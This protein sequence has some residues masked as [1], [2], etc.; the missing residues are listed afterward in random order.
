MAPS[1]RT[2]SRP[3]AHPSREL[4]EVDQGVAC[5]RKHDVPVNNFVVVYGDI[6]ETYGSA[7]STGQVGVDGTAGSQA[8]E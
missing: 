7:Q 5:Q 6:S 8:G 3:G 2:S 1:I 4:L